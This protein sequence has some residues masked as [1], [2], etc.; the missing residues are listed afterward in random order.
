MIG[1]GKMGLNHL[2]A[3]SGCHDVTVVGVADPVTTTEALTGLVPQGCLITG[4]AAAMLDQARPDVVHIVTPPTTHVPLAVMALRRG[5]HVY[6]EKPVANNA[7]EVETL[8]EAARAAGRL[9]CAGHQCL[10]DHAAAHGRDRLKHLGTI[11]HV[12]SHFSFRQVRR[13]ISPVD[14]AKDILPHAIYMLLDYLRAS[15]PDLE[16]ATP[17]LISADCDAAGGAYGLVKLGDCRGTFSVTLTG[18]PVE[19]YL[20]VSG[21]NGS[22]RVDL[23]RGSVVAL[24]GPGASLPAAMGDPYR[25]SWQMLTQST[26]GFAR[27]IRERKY[28]YPGHRELCEAFYQHIRGAGPVPM[29][30]ASILETVTISAEVGRDLEAAHEVAEATANARLEASTRALPPPDP[31]R[32]IVAVTGAAGF[33]GKVL[34]TELRQQGYSVRALCRQMPRISTRVPG[35]DYVAADLGRPL[36]PEAFAGATAVVHCA[37]ETRGGKDDH[38]RN[39]IGA[40][41]HVVDATAVAG[42]SRLINI[43]SVAVMRPPSD[44]GP[45]SETTPID[46]DLSRGPYVWGKAQAERTAVAECARLGIGLRTIRLGPLV[47]FESFDPPGRLGRDIGLAFLAVGPKHRPLA[48]VDVRVAAQVI[49]EVLRDFDASPVLMNLVQ[50]TAPTRL[51]LVQLMQAR[52]PSLSVIWIPAIGLRLMNPLLNLMQRLILGLKQPLDVASAFSSPTYNTDLAAGVIA[53]MRPGPP[54]ASAS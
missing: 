31:S 53:R 12:H 51:D 35:V 42:I 43:G 48:L 7:A 30:N 27:H 54:H 33:L 14:Q 52:H 19:Q 34:V 18:R 49:A 16:A 32:G 22:L 44:G 21:T 15:R 11:V 40:T 25:E 1:A 20:H 5:V 10:F 9:V 36:P 24:T 29:S 46:D 26:T 38:V 8:F 47:D 6:I 13:S 2:R 45:M 50:P 4:D 37:A 28:G 41:Q 39:S 23:V 17:A 3:I